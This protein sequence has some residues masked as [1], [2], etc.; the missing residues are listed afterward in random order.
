[1]TTFLP[2][3]QSPL[4]PLPLYSTSPP[5]HFMSNVTQHDHSVRAP[6]GLVGQFHSSESTVTG[7][8]SYGN[9]KS[10]MPVPKA[11]LAPTANGD[12]PHRNPIP[13]A[14]GMPFNAARSPPNAKSKHS[15]LFQRRVA[16]Y[17]TPDTSHVP[18]K[19]FRLGQCQA[20]KACPFSHSTDVSSV[21]TPCK[22]FA[23]VSNPLPLTARDASEYGSFELT[24]RRETANSA[25][26]VLWRT[27]SQMEDA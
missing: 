15:E 14:G 22:Y 18:C 2:S 17:S 1:M 12:T 4:E 3:Q 8:P 9:T 20:G 26:N 13:M 21:D 23:K 16:A 10:S 25:P 27:S 7:N 5:D 11:P 24:P 6:N 19:F